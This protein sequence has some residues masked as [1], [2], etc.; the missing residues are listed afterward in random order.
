MCA[1]LTSIMLGLVVAGAHIGKR[2]HFAVTRS[3]AQLSPSGQDPPTSPPLTTTTTA[4]TKI[5][6]AKFH[7]DIQVVFCSCINS[8]G[9]MYP[10][11][12]VSHS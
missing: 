9:L 3:R 6:A 5:M 4:I 7:K 11:M 10:S 12:Q 8:L 2:L 1:C